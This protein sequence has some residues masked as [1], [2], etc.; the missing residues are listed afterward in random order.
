MAPHPTLVEVAKEGADDELTDYTLYMTLSANQRNGA[1]AQ[2]FKDLA[3]MEKR[4]LDFWQKFVPDYHPRLK[5]RLIRR[6]LLFK[7]IFGL[8]FAIRYLERHEDE[9]IRRYKAAAHLVPAEDKAAFDE[10]LADEEHHENEFA[11]RI[12]S[13]TIRYISFV[14]LGLADALVEITGIH[15]GSLGIYNKTEIAGLAG[16]I[17]GGAAS[18]AMASA[19]Y[20]QAKQGFKGSAGLSAGYTGVSYFVTAIILA[21][22]YFLTKSQL[23]AISISLTLAVVIVTFASYYGSVIAT[24]PFLHD[25]LELLVILFC[26][27]VALYLF[28]VFIRAETGVTI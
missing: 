6:V 19:A 22:P 15:A 25:Y 12:E 18:L 8:T 16:V 23:E 14:V 21:T 3:V 13:S 28:G 27:T 4:H 1:S 7:R 10:V 5:A 2:V 20:A 17:A 26:V 11:S 9:S 24:Q